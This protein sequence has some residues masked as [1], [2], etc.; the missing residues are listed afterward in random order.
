MGLRHARELTREEPGHDLLVLADGSQAIGAWQV[1]HDHTA[2]LDL[3]LTLA[4]LHG[5]ARVVADLGPKPRERVKECGLPGVRASDQAEPQNSLTHAA[6]SLPGARA[7][8][9]LRTRTRA[10]SVCRR[11]KR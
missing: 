5:D 10:P 3:R 2:T 6:D 1:D 9:S 11:H 4:T 7:A 8:S